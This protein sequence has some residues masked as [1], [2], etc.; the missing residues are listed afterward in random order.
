MGLNPL[1][2]NAVVLL[3]DEIASIAGLGHTAPADS[4]DKA[5]AALV[6]L[7]N[8]YELPIV[9]T[10]IAWGTP[11]KLTAAVREAVGD[12]VQV[13]VRQ[14]T[15]SFDDPAILSAI[16]A[17]GR[18]T[19]LIAGIVTEIAVQRAALGGKAR[20]F[21]TQ[22]VFD[23]CNGF[24]ERSEDVAMHRMSEAGV[25]LTSVPAVVG[26]LAF[27]LSDPRTPKAFGVL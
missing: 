5:A 6:N 9:I 8:L 1:S 16:E 25:V 11:P 17:T 27:D 3:I 12:E 10:G 21:D 22:V 20:G 4:V 2:T 14:T 7:A 13:N 24:S 23:A 18:K 19:V 15:D 26:E